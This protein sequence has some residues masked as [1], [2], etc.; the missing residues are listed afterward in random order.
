MKKSFKIL[1]LLGFIATTL[2]L[3][4]VSTTSVAG[5]HPGYK[6][7]FLRN[8]CKADPQYVCRL[9]DWPTINL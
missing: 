9:T 6:K 3:S 2:S 7:C 8:H 1:T 4:L 5:D